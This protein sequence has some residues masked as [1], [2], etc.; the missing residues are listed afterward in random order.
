MKNKGKVF[1]S[2]FQKSIPSTVHCYRFKDSTSSWD[3]SNTSFAIYNACDF[4]LY[5]NGNLYWLELKSHLG[6]SLPLSCIR[7]NQV[8]ELTKAAEKGVIAGLL[9]EFRDVNRV[10]WLDINDYNEFVTEWDRKSIPLNYF[11]EAGI[12][13]EVKNL[14]VHKRYDISK[15]LKEM[16]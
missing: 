13:I 8:K 5:S 4:E 1:E 16:E 14:R 2:N 15:F 6:K 12:E 11:E 10:F 9:V 3:N 7:D